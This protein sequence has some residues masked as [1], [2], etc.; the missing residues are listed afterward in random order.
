MVKSTFNP[1]WTG[2]ILCAILAATINAMSSQVLVLS[3]SLTEDVYKRMIRPL[4]TSKELLLVSRVGVAIVALIAFLIA[5]GE[6]STIYSL[7]LYAWSGLGSSFGPLL[8][9]SLY[10]K[11]ITKQGAW[12]GILVG[13]AIAAFWPYFNQTIPSMIPGFS[14]SILSI[15]LVSKI[16]SR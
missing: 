5:F 3:S 14:L 16:S 9:L 10:S 1:F 7:V 11:T 2:L 8:V 13:G 12:A 4:A 6:F 15:R